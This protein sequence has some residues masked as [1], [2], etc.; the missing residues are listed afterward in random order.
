MTDASPRDEAERH[1]LTSGLSYG[2][3]FNLLCERFYARVDFVS[4]A[5]QLVGGSAAAFSVLQS[6]ADWTTAAGIGLAL[7]AAVSLLVQPA[8]KAERH[9]RAK[10]AYLEL[11]AKAADL[12][13][14]E[15]R[16]E[17]ARVRGDAPTGIDALAVPALNATLRARTEAGAEPVFVRESALQRLARMIG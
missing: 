10:C 17:L 12:S 11:E 14:A 4:N 8:I 9:R 2:Y 5:V 15:L 7:A 3:W 1:E 13:T 16:R 6:R